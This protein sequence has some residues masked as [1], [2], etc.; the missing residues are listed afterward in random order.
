MATERVTERADGP[1]RERV[2]EREGGDTTYVD[3]GG[4]G[5]GGVIVGIAILAL[6]A[7]IAFFLLNQSRND[8]LRTRAVTS[9]ASAVAD[10]ATGAA[11]T[12]GDAAQ[13][14]ADNT[15]R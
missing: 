10:S 1:I 15:T 8:N 6:V 7:I 9:A 2:V 13:G 4:S 3:R 11:R 12:A 5:I 14:A